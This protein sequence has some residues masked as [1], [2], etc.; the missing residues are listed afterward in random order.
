[1]NPI[2]FLKT[3]WMEFYA[4]AKADKLLGNFRYLK[5]HRNDPNAGGERRNFLPQRGYCYGYAPFHSTLDLTRLEANARGK[6]VDGVDVVFIARRPKKGGV[7]VVGWYR[8]ARVYSTLQDIARHYCLARAREYELLDID[9]RTLQIPVTATSGP[10]SPAVW[11]GSAD[12]IRDVRLLMAGRYRA[13]HARRSASRRTVD[14]DVEQRS[15]VEKAAVKAVT[16]LYVSRGYAVH[17]VERANVGWD[18]HADRSGDSLQIEV[19]GT[20]HPTITADL[21]PN[22]YAAFEPPAA[23]YR[24]CLVTSALGTPEVHDFRYSTEIAAW[25]NGS[26]SGGIKVKKL[27]SA[28]IRL[29]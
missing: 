12:A 23:S 17:S 27:Q 8:N 28:R 4:G 26:G 25:V 5:E 2:L 10:R 24:L 21:T 15:A 1:M 7:F 11:F 9:D 6:H 29:V 22:E 19:K 13:P 18:L 16:S 14:P 20:S 3:G